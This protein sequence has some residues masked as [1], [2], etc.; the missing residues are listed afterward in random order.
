MENEE[1]KKART[2]GEAMEMIVGEFSAEVCWLVIL[3]QTWE[4]L[5]QEGG[6]SKAQTVNL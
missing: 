4:A 2:I 6:T 3:G 5:I 1:M